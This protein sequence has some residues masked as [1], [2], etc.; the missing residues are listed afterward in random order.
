NFLVRWLKRNYLRQLERCLNHRWLTLGLFAAIMVAT[1]LF[2]VP[3]LGREFMPELEEGNLW[4]RA[5]FPPHTSLEEVDRQRE[6][7]LTIMRRYPEV[8]AIVT[9]IGRP[10]DGTDPSGFNILQIFAP[11]KAERSW[12]IPPGR[13]R[14]RTKAE[15][16]AEMNQELSGKIVGVNW[17]FSQYI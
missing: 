2:A 16:V 14:P 10:D 3:R 8:E 12:P 7:A 6:N 9:Q 5:D 11:L 4:I 17:N 1:T 15:L 13:D